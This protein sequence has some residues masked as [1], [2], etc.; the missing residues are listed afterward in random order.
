MEPLGIELAERLRLPDAV[1]RAAIRSRVGRR[2][3]LESRG[4][5]EAQSERL[6]ALIADSDRGQIA[7]AT[8]AANLQHYEVPAEFFALCLGP[9]RKYSCALWT[10]GVH[11]L[12]AA[13]QAMLALYAER[14][15]L[16]DGQEMLDLG[17]GW[18]SLTLWL[19]E[20][21][22]LSTVTGVSNS[23][24]Q[25]AYIEQAAATR[26][27]TNV[28]VITADVNAFVPDRTFDR[29]L[30]V[31]MLEHVRN[32]RALLARVASWLRPE[33]RLFVHVF[34]HRTL[35]F[36]FDARARSDWIARHFFTGGTMPCDDLLPRVADDLTLVD[37]WCV[38]GMHYARTARA[39][40]ERVDRNR[41]AA[42]AVLAT[43]V[44]RR[45]ARRQLRRWRLFFLACEG[46]WGYDDG[47]QFI[48]S[49]YLFR[50]ARTPG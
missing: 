24:S 10:D 44:G 16:H 50:R 20:Q 31:E 18:G 26:G 11:D 49:H 27:L 47:S 39:W 35:A 43:Q 23:A 21:Y 30:S 25:R 2:I 12:A 5:V 32:H 13:E 1:L 3:R 29:I 9:R 41:E 45:R 17:C 6:R 7:V 37:Q 28:R 36:R 33:G 14:A 48:V 19:A 46:L 15:E 38:S 34:S 42:R 8:D 40:L 4:G 22:P